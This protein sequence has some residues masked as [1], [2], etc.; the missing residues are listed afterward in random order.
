MA[1][2]E[3]DL[4]S[5]DDGYQRDTCDAAAAMLRDAGIPVKRTVLPGSSYWNDWTKYPFSATE[6]NQR[7]LGIQVMTLAYRS[8]EPWNESGFSNERFDTLLAQ[9]NSIADADERRAVMVEL[10]TILREEGVIIQPYWRSTFRHYRENVTG[11]E[12]H[13]TFEIH[14]YKLG[15]AAS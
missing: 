8:G 13:P 5:I 12:M 3:H 4:V 15:L 9:A 7:P 14:P 1:D 11:A 6:W 2:F 10:E